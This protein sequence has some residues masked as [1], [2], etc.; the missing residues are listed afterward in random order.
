MVTK[1]ALVATIHLNASSPGLFVLT[2]YSTHHATSHHVP[3]VYAV[4]ASLAGDARQL[5]HRAPTGMRG[6]DVRALG[7]FSSLPVLR[8]S[9]FLLHPHHDRRLASMPTFYDRQ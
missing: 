9:F 2:P 3:H 8:T 6:A 1:R 7:I 4:S 5:L